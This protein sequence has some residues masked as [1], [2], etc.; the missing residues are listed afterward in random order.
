MRAVCSMRSAWISTG[1]LHHQRW[2]SLPMTR[3]QRYSLLVLTL[4]RCLMQLLAIFPMSRQSSSLVV[5]ANTH[6]LQISRQAVP[7]PIQA[8]SPH[9]VMWHFSCTQA[10]QRAGQKASCSPIKTF[11][12]SFHLLKKSGSSPTVRSAL[13]QCR[14]FTLAAADGQLWVWRLAASQSSF[15]MS[16]QPK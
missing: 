3:P 5:T 2:H 6:R 11:L 7:Q 10:A 8:S 4:F 12:H 14:S 13:L 9:L 15:A 1:G 16:T